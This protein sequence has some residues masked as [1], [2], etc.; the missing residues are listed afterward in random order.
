[1]ESPTRVFG[2]KLVVMEGPARISWH[3]LVQGLQVPVALWPSAQQRVQVDRCLAGIDSMLIVL[4][5]TGPTV[6]LLPE[7]AH[8][9]PE[10]MRP[11]LEQGDY[12]FELRIPLLDWLPS[13]LA[14]RGMRFRESCRAWART[15]PAPILPA[16]LIEG[17]VEGIAGAG[18]PWEREAGAKADDKIRFAWRTSS[19]PIADSALRQLAE[20][21]F[22]SPDS[23]YQG[24]GTHPSHAATPRRERAAW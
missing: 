7:E 1:M 14:E 18:G 15:V 24:T 16:L 19:M 6:S 11:L 20:R 23:D 4:G 22:P 5:C 3:T 10:T 13:G 17:G 9:V 8:R 2:D 21:I 12:L